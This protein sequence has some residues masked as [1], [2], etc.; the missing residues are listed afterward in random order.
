MKGQVANL[1][2]FQFLR[3]DCIDFMCFV[4]QTRKLKRNE[5][6]AAAKKAVGEQAAQARVHDTRSV[7][8]V[9]A[10][11]EGIG[12]KTASNKGRAA[13]KGG[14]KKAQNTGGPGVIKSQDLHAPAFPSET[15]AVLGTPACN[16]S[17]LHSPRDS[18]EVGSLVSPSF[19]HAHLL[20]HLC[21]SLCAWA[22]VCMC[23]RVCACRVA[24]KRMC[25]QPCR[26][27]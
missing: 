24:C 8:D 23:I 14:K 7:D 25:V 12:K 19:V 26:H 16:Q 9:L 20:T 2:L 1:L 4:V 6:A 5:A 11:I 3:T 22:G 10:E 21:V 27:D 17:A 15:S 13:K 18:C